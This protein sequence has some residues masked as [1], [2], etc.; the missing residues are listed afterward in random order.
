MK[1]VLYVPDLKKN[2]LSIS[3]LEKKGFRVS[4]VDGKVLMW[5][6]AKTID[7]VNEAC[8]R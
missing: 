2:F 5:P 6:K 4:F 1:D 3:G 8:T 7:D